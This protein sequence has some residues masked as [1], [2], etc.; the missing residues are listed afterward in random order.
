MVLTV[1]F[2][3]AEACLR[4]MAP[5]LQRLVALVAMSPRRRVPDHVFERRK[6]AYVNEQTTSHWP[7]RFDA[8]APVATVTKRDSD[9]S[10]L[11]RWLIGYRD[12]SA[13]VGEL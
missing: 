5:T 2:P 11:R 4:D 13:A 7:I 12:E 1:Q 3:V 10:P 6:T 9:L 8:D